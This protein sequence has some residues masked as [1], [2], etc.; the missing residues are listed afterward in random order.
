MTLDVDRLV[1]PATLGRATL[2]WRMAVTIAV[3][4][5]GMRLVG[6]PMRLAA[7]LGLVVAVNLAGLVVVSRWP[8]VV[9]H[10]YLIVALD[11][12]LV[13][14]T[15]VVSHGGVA[16]FC[17]AVGAC[18]LA[19]ILLGARG[20]LLAL[21]HAVLGYI[22]A[23]GVLR[24]ISAAPEAATFV[25]AFPMADVLA[26]VGGAV[27]AATLTHQVNLSVEVV[28]SAQRTAA[29]SERARLARELHDSVA[30]TLRGVSFAAVALPSSWRRDPVMAEKLASTVSEGAN[31]AAREA[32]ELLDGLRLDNPDQDFAA[33]IFEISERWAQACG[34]TVRLTTSPAEPPVEVRYELGR[35]LHEAL[36]NISRHAGATRVEVDLVSEPDELRLQVTDDG[37]GFTM[38]AKLAVLRADKHYGILGMHERAQRIG[39]TLRVDSTPGSGTTIRVR[40][41]VAGA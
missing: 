40:V 38:P 27:A 14:A 21:L 16:Y 32:R 34:I 22:V 17:C 8:Q 18:A 15:L 2:L 33:T 37:C 36:S 41:P 3:A 12:L 6:Q 28:A 5:V 26:G 10:P 1:V 35:I 31:A 20:P 25:L 4:G 9:R 39:G 13:G 19:G 30:K 11:A 23:A 7:T 24:D 29:A